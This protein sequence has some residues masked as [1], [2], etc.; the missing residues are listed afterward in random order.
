MIAII[1]KNKPLIISIGLLYIFSLNSCL[2]DV[3]DACF[4]TDF[5]DYE[6]GE[7]ITFRN[8]SDPATDYLWDFGDG[9]QMYGEEVTYVYQNPGDFTVTLTAYFGTDTKVARGTIHVTSPTE[10]RITTYYE[11]SSVTVAGVDVILYQSLQ[12]WQ[13][14]GNR[15]ASGITDQ[16]GEITFISDR[17]NGFNLNPQEYFIYASRDADNGSGYYSNE[18]TNFSTSILN[19]GQLNLFDVDLRFS[20]YKKKK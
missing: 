20:P 7:T 9:N 19:Q 5:D 2:V 8:C 15:I 3:N 17:T 14:D 16:Y 18:E 11:G 4:S 10:L 12:D 13:Q 6:V 1:M